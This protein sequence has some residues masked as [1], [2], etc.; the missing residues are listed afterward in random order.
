MVDNKTG[1]P[2]PFGTLGV[3]KVQYYHIH[4]ALIFCDFQRTAFKEATCCLFIFDI[5]YFN[6]ENLMSKLACPHARV[7]FKKF[8]FRLKKIQQTYGVY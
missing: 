3:H 8:V 1:N 7:D 5:L 4:L 6:G 2:L